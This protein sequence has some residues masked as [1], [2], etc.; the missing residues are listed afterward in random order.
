MT[1]GLLPRKSP[2]QKCTEDDEENVGHPDQKF[3]MHFRITAERIGDDDEKKIS[4]RHD[5]AH[6]EAD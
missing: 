3:R 1:E 6:R 4:D 2:K 5:E